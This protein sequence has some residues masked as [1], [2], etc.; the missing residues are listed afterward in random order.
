[1]PKIKPLPFKIRLAKSPTREPQYSC[2]VKS[3]NGKIVKLGDPMVT[4]GLVALMNMYAVN[5]GAACHWGGPSAFAEIMSSIHGIMFK[6]KGDAWYDSYHFVND[7]GHTENGV[8]ALRAN[9]G[10]D[11]LSFEDLWSFRGINSK[12][13]GH[14][15]AHVNPEGVLVSNGPLGSGLPQAQGLAMADAL[16][17]NS[18]L[19]ICTISDGALMEGE[20]K[21]SLAAIPGL[22]AKGKMNPFL[23]VI[24]YNRTK[25]SGRIEEDSFSMD[26][27]IESISTL[28][29]NVV[30]VKEGHNLEAVY[31]SIEKAVTSAQSHPKQPCCLIFDTVKGYGVKST[32][33]APS[34]GHGYPLKKGDKKLIDFL[35]EIFKGSV[36]TLFLE[37][38][39]KLIQD[40]S[41]G[42]ESKVTVTTPKEKVQV[43][44]GKALIKAVESGYPV[45]SIS[46]DLQSSTGVSAFHKKFP[47]RFIEVG[48]AESNMISSAVGLSLCGLIPVVDTFAQF[49]VTKGNLPLTMS[50][51]SEAPLIAIFSHTGMQDAA[52]GASHQATTYW[53]ATKSLPHTEIISCSCSMEAESYLLE[54]IKRFAD[55]RQKGHHGSSYLFFLG[56]EDF[57]VN[58]KEG[59]TYDWGKPQL[60]HDSSKPQLLITAT[61]PTVGMALQA[62]QQLSQEGIEV[63]I[64]NHP[65]ITHP[66]LPLF[67]E[68][69]KRSGSKLLTIEDHQLIGGMGERLS[70]ALLMDGVLFKYKGL[71]IMG[72]FGR[73]AYSATELYNLFHMGVADVVKGVKDLL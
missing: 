11:H 8:Y 39:Q 22:A 17:G 23:M 62:A 57:P 56:R 41:C 44:I 33:E 55:D 9:L 42:G 20:A 10:Y 48:V 37:T 49:G 63:L 40:G 71:G 70:H 15:E 51:L 60:L 21:E 67:K 47:D 45:F 35:E 18:R 13:T 27:T 66:D 61:G 53:S 52:D 72:H 26:P 16:L 24:S 14:G 38:A 5:K 29:W 50:A 58:F 7:A 32:E 64:V 6:N 54:A 46:A 25:L 28:G 65:F 1:M 69:L 59:V 30:R 43:G 36:P 73:S 68:W 2:E 31:Q 19:T 3:V 4:R 12:L 34:G